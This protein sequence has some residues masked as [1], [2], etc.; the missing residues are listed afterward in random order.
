MSNER[1]VILI[2]LSLAFIIGLAFPL[3]YFNIN[4]LGRATLTLTGF[5][6]SIN[7]VVGVAGVILMTLRFKEQWIPWII[8]D[9]AMVALNVVIGQW[10]MAAMYLLWTA[11][12]VIGVV[13]W[14]KTNKP[15]VVAVV[16]VE[17]TG[18]TTMVEFLHK[19][20][21]KNLCA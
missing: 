21:S 3:S 18:K 13:N 20:F 10:A 15:K 5:L 8:V 6:D 19:R 4:T 2:A 7:L 12:A 9:T 1:S 16:G 14:Y 11:N 17:S